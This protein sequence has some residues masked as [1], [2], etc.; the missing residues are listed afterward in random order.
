MTHA[1]D[2]HFGDDPALPDSPVEIPDLLP[3]QVLTR[4]VPHAEELRPRGFLIICAVCEARRDW[5]IVEVLG[6]VYIRCRCTHEWLEPDLDL[7]AFD[8]MFGEVSRV[9]DSFAEVTTGLGFDG[10]FAGT[11]LD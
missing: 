2:D 9:W 7:T 4:S 1:D 8:A 5:L 3:G 10:T 6:K 11:Y